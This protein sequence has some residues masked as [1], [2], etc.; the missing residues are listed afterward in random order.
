M[1]RKPNVTIDDP[2]FN[3]FWQ[4][5]PK[6]VARLDALKAWVSLKPTPELVGRMLRA[7]E[8]QRTQT[9]WLK[10]RGQFIPYPASWIRQGRW[11]DEIDEP[12]AGTEWHCEHEPKCLGRNACD[13]QRRIAAGKAVSR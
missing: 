4:A 2:Q 13:V 6:R 10:E 3:R 12:R 11:M 1:P 8:Q 7:L 5:Y 9:S